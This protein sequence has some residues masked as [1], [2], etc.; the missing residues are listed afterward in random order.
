MGT[1]ENKVLST[2][3]L[4]RELAMLMLR[5]VSKLTPVQSS[6]KFNKDNLDEIDLTVRILIAKG[7]DEIT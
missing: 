2:R 4:F 1:L 5:Q 6:R 3:V 7:L